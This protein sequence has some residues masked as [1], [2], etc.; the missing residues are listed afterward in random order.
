MFHYDIGCTLLQY[1]NTQSADCEEIIDS[2]IFLIV[3]QLS[4]VTSQN[5]QNQIMIAELNHKAASKAMRSSNY[6]AALIYSNTAASHL[7]NGNWENCYELSRGIFLM[8]A[9]SAY[10]EGKA[11][12][13]E[14]TL[15]EVIGKGK[16]LKD[17]LEAYHLKIRLTMAREP[18]VAYDIGADVLRMLDEFIPE[19][20]EAARL[21]SKAKEIRVK[22]ETLTEHDVSNMSVF[23]DEIKYSIMQLYTQGM[24]ELLCI[25]CESSNAKVVL[26]PVS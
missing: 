1:C 20:V 6:N 17:K 15:D 9:Y 25:L 24:N 10:A 5:P 3:D 13:A 12:L 19:I 14:K 26:L 7:S 4:H 23:N 8:L 16:T 2:M 21:E 22:I 18:K 11:E